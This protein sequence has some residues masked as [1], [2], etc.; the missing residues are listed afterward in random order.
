MNAGQRVLP[1][2]IDDYDRKLLTDVQRHGWHVL[3]IQEDEEGPAFAYSVGLEWSFGHP[4]IAVFGLDLDLMHRMINEIGEGI[5]KGDRFHDLDESGDVLDGFNVMFRRVD[6]R[7]HR[8]H[9][10]YALWFAQGAPLTLLQCIWPDN[11]HRFPW[12]PGFPPS[13]SMRQPLLTDNRDWPFAE[14]RNRAVFATRP[15][16]SGTSPILHVFHDREGDWQFVCGTTTRTE[17]L[18]LV[19]LGHLIDRDGS[20]KSLADLPVGW[21]ASR[22][23]D[24]G[25]WRR[26]KT[27]DEVE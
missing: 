6:A 23:T 25:E 9:F 26:E 4:E 19:S 10:G 14:G 18:Q 1:T 13:L 16:T 17:D 27:R 12:H 24:A 11:R 2:P 21:C 22:S 7:H 15:V 5:R 3:K 8:E 20:L